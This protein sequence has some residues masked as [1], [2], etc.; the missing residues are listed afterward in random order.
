VG[1]P[2]LAELLAA[3][4]GGTPLGL[5]ATRRAM[6]E[7]HPAYAPMAAP[8]TGAS[9]Y[10]NDTTAGGE[11]LFGERFATDDGRAHLRAPL[12][13]PTLLARRAARY[14]ATEV[15]LERER[16]RLFGGGSR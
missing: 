14:S 12:L 9:F 6:V 8:E 16:A 15:W 1:L 10:W 4:T 2:A 3:V 13:E 11:S 5:E 7:R